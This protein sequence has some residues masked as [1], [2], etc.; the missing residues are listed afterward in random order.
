MDG[1]HAQ[2][3]RKLLF[4]TTELTQCVLKLTN[5]LTLSVQT[6]VLLTKNVMVPELAL[7][8]DG[9]KEL[10]LVLIILNSLT[11]YVNILKFLL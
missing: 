6:H 1:A 5:L 9:A 2:L 7:L 10:T 8:M 3:T 11:L 4:M